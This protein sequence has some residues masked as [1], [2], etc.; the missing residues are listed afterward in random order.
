MQHKATY[1]V[2]CVCV[3]APRRRGTIDTASGGCVASN[4]LGPARLRVVSGTRRTAMTQS[5]G[6]N[7][8]SALL[9]GVARCAV[10]HKAIVVGVWLGLA[11]ALALAFP[12]LETVVRRQSMDPVPRDI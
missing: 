10:R 6:A 3:V 1:V 12:Q 5:S 9:A 11:V 8:Y 7:H 2:C 4:D